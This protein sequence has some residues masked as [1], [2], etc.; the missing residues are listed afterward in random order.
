M[1]AKSIMK[2]TE[3]IWTD[4]NKQL[5]N[6]IYKRVKNSDAAKDLLQ[7]I[8]V[9]IHLNLKN[10]HNEE[11]LTSWVYQITRNSILDYFKKNKHDTDLTK[12]VTDEIEPS[13]FNEE[14]TKCLVPFIDKLTPNYKE[15]ILKTEIGNL[16]QKDYAEELGISYSGAKSRVQR[17]REELNIL[18]KECCEINVDVYGNVID[19]QVCKKN[20]G[21]YSS[22]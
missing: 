8:F 16:S 1:E 18:F 11:K 14:L 5:Y 21:C 9:K 22:R 2:T 6:F 10:L 12:D 17:A 3:N 7:D 20:C 13:N 15:A 4:F 19:H